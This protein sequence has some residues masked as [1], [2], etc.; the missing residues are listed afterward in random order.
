MQIYFKSLFCT[1][2]SPLLV[3]EASFHE[4][5]FIDKVKLRVEAGHGGSGAITFFRDR[6]TKFGA[7]DGGDG[8]N[9]GDVVFRASSHFQDLRIVKNYS[10]KGNDGKPGSRCMRMG[11]NGG[12]L[13]YNVPVGTLSN[14]AFYFSL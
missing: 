5:K 8:G 10:V 1:L 14:G 7:G 6:L 12:T 4:R 2:T 9:G 11:F 13:V 3:K